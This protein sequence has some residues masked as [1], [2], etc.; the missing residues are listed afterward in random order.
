MVVYCSENN[1]RYTFAYNKNSKGGTN[2]DLI[3]SKKKKNKKLTWWKLQRP[4]FAFCSLDA[5]HLTT[6]MSVWF[7][8][9][10]RKQVDITL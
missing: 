4:T 1:T 9:D 5:S 10:N 6:N 2:S 3:N 7:N 8:T